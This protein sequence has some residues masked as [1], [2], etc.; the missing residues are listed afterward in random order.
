MNNPTP[1]TPSLADRPLPVAIL[2]ALRSAVGE[3]H[4]LAGLAE[5]YAYCRDRAPYGTF[6]LREGELPCRLPGAVVIPADAIELRGLV[7]LANRMKI[8]LIPFGAGS[9]VLGGTVP[10]GNEVIVDLKR[11][12]QLLELNETDATV[13]VQPGL[14]GARFEALL[15]DRGW[16]CG[17]LPQLIAMS[18]VGGWAACRGAGQASS[19]Y[20]KIED[21]VLGLK[22][23]LPD[24]RELEVRPVAR[25]S[26]GPSIKDLMVGSEGT[27]GF[28]T[29]LTL[30]LW[31]K[32]V[33]EQAQVLAFA[34]HELGLAALR[35]IMQAELRPQVARLYDEAE[36]RSRTQGVAGFD[37]Q[38]VLCI[39]KFAG[40]PRLAALEAE[41][42]LEI[43]ARHGATPGG[44]EPYVQWEKTRYQAYSTQWQT[45][46][47]YMDTIEIV[48]P[49]SRLSA[50][51]APMRDAVVSLAP[52]CHFGAHWS[53][54]YPE[55]TCQYMTLRLP[56]M[57]HERAL[58]L[59]HEAWRRVQ[60]LCLMHGGSMAHHHGVGW[61][62]GEWM[63]TELG[64]G[65]TL[66]Q[67][68]KDAVDPNNLC[69]PG[70]LGL[71]ARDP[72]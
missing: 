50:M 12:D 19:R 60:S 18:T 3:A 8:A 33:H 20:G 37:T 15:N 13:T 17:H 53:H 9:G 48:A 5:R 23:L 30:R 56:P 1:P 14:N 29:E 7:L 38:P 55:G 43:A 70:K 31:R 24:G 26:V 27:L 28:I 32:P 35:D 46:G 16:T 45:E 11:L 25:R 42:A 36:S 2:Q 69:N 39:L 51:F 54:V 6:R 68:L 49:W 21:M 22:A 57:P 4:V 44:T 72:L 61:L 58:A 40:L 67:A 65:L 71:H 62:R 64:T 59:H 34:S 41:L 47:W 63:S 66:L 52:G 10:L